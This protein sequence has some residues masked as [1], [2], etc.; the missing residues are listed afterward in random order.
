MITQRKRK[1]FFVLEAKNVI[2]K[3][4][5]ALITSNTKFKQ[6]LIDLG[7]E[8]SDIVCL[9]SEKDELNTNINL[10]ILNKT[11]ADIKLEKTQTLM[12]A[13]E[14]QDIIMMADD[15]YTFFRKKNKLEEI[16]P[17]IHYIRKARAD[18]DKLLPQLK[19]NLY[20]MYHD[21]K[22]KIVWILNN[23]I[24][25]L[26]IK[27]NNLRV[28]LRGDKTNSGNQ[29]LF[30]FCFSLPDEGKIA[31]TANGQYSLGMFEVKSDSSDTMIVALNE[32]TE[33][34]RIFNS[35]GHNYIIDWHLSGDMVWM[36]TERGLNGCNLKFPCFKC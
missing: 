28:C 22:E 36:K 1:S 8:I 13:C 23:K 27:N 25:S 35:Y 14:S 15:D 34:M 18:L 32:L 7:I 24:N 21:A 9:K 19:C 16:L 20:G 11:R 3:Q 30:N 26:S 10:K 2:I 29:S 5:L 31:K 12:N 33:N 4:I 6:L 17:S